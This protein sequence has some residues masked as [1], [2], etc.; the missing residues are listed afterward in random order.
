ML[1]YLYYKFYRAA[2]RSSLADIAAFAAAVWLA[3]SICMNVLAIQVLLAKL[4]LW[5]VIFFKEIG[6]VMLTCIGISV[7]YFFYKKRYLK[8]L[9]HYTCESEESRKRGNLLMWIYVIVTFL[10]VFPVAFFK[11]GYVP[12]I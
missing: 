2:E 4:D 1:H 11:P 10:L 7:V 3:I 8:I 5:K 9:N 6:W 12:Q